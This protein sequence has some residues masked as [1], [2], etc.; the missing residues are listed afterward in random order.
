MMRQR[1][2]LGMWRTPQGRA[3]AERGLLYLCLALSCWLSSLNAQAQIVATKL[4]S[5][6]P[7]NG[8]PVTIDFRPQQALS[9]GTTYVWDLGRGGTVSGYYVTGVYPTAGT[10][11]VR[12]VVT[13][14]AGVSTTYDQTI[15]IFPPP[16][17][18]FTSNKTSGCFPLSVN[19]QDGTVP[20]TGST[21]VYR[22]WFFGDGNK[23]GIAN[24]ANTYKDIASAYNV[25]LRVVQDVCIGDTFQ[26]TRTSYI[27]VSEGVKPD[28]VMP[29]TT[30]CKVPATVTAQNRSTTGPG[31]TLS[32][33]W[34]VTGGTSSDNNAINF[35]A[36][37]ATAGNFTVKLVARSNGGC[38]DSIEKPISI[39][40][41]AVRSDF[42]IPSDTICQDIVVPFINNSS[43]FVSGSNIAPGKST[44]Y[45]GSDPAIEG[46]NQFKTFKATGNIQIKLVNEFGACKDSVTKLIH[47]I[48]SPDITV[49]GDRFSCKAPHLVNFSYTGAPA[50]SL[51]SIFWEFGNGLSFNGTGPS[52]ANA[53]SNYTTTGS[54]A[55]SLTVRNRFGCQ[56]RKIIDSFVV[57]APPSI[58]SSK[59]T[60]SGCVNF[61]FRPQVNIVAPDGVASYL[62]NFGDGTTQTNPNPTHTY[63]TA[64]TAPYPVSVTIV[65]NRGCTI[66][67]QG[68]VKIGVPPGTANFSATPRSLC[69]GQSVQFTDLSIPSPKGITGWYW[70]FGAGSARTQNPNYEYRDTGNFQVSLTV[71]NN[72]CPSPVKAISDYIRVGGAAAYFNDKNDCANRRQFQF[73]YST[74]IG[75][76]FEWDFGDGTTA[77]NPPDGF[78]HR[79]PADASYLVTVKASDGICSMSTSSRITVINET[80][81]YS[82]RSAFTTNTC[83]TGAI[84]FTA[85]G[86]IPANI[87]LYEWD[88]GNGVFVDG[89]SSTSH[90]YTI[91]GVYATRL[92]ITDKYRCTFTTAGPPLVIGSPKPSFQALRTQQCINLPVQF[93]DTSRTTAAILLASR[94][95]S[96]GDGTQITV[97]ASQ[98]T[99]QH[100]Y[101]SGG[102]Y[103]VK[104]ILKAIN[105]CEDSAMLNSYVTV[106][107]PIAAFNAPE[108]ES[109]SGSPVTF[110]NQSIL[111]GGS[112]TWDFG[113]GSSS[114]L[115]NPTHSYTSTGLYAVQLKVQDNLGCNSNIQKLDYIRVDVP[116]ASFNVSATFSSCPPFSPTFTFTGSYARS[117]SWDFGDGN[118]SNLATPSQIYLYPNTYSTRLTVTSPGGCTATSPPISIQVRGP[119]ATASMNNVVGCDSVR[120]QFSI[121]N[122]IDVTRV[123]WD[124][125]DGITSNQFVSSESHVYR[126]PG[127]YTPKII[128][129][130]TLG[131]KI[132][133]LF[134]LKVRNYGVIAGF[135]N[136]RTLFCDTGS[137]SLL[138]TSLI[139]GTLQSRSWNFGNGTNGTVANPTVKYNAPGRYD[140]TLMHTL[141]EG[142]GS[143]IVKPALVSVVQSPKPS[144]FTSSTLCPGQPILLRGVEVTVPRDTSLLQWSWDFGNG[145]RSTLQNPASQTYPTAGS[146][147]V[148]LQLKNSSGCIDSATQLL[149]IDTLPDI[150]VPSDTA[151]C[152]GKPASL[153]ASGASTYRWLPPNQGITCTTCPI[154]TVVPDSNR[155][156]LVEGTNS[157]GCV[158]YN[159]IRVEVIRPPKLTVTNLHNICIGGTARL[160]ASG[161]QFYAW[162]P[163][164]GL[165]DPTIANPIARPAATTL[166]VVTGEDRKRCFQTKDTARVE[167]YNFPSVFIGPTTTIRSGT[168]VQLKPVTSSDVNSYNWTPS[169]GLSCTNCRNPI[170]KPKE[171]IIYQL[172]ASNPGGCTSS[173]QVKVVVICDAENIYMPNTFS[174]NGDGMNEVF[175]GRGIG[176]KSIRGLRIFNRW[177][178]MVFQR[179]NVNIN[180]PSHGWDGRYKGKLLPPD[181]Y[182]YFIDVICDNFGLVTRKGDVA[183]I[184]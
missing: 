144:I 146:Y 145:L 116:I 54:F 140:I 71:F 1:H 132:P 184:R 69:A 17:I 81:A 42:T 38:V 180:D 57:I 49:T 21:I 37:F 34:S 148:K 41:L 109:C 177:G 183:L 70:Q 121:T 67:I 108:R 106:S 58:T 65:T 28:F 61:V 51:S 150:I 97:P 161:A 5:C 168:S 179:Q 171:T 156:Y 88:F 107:Q 92:R 163:T 182:V 176:V 77:L 125:D 162:S 63:T 53:S 31:Q 94:T 124:F 66:Q 153:Q 103:N 99:T 87:K 138:D 13:T 115:A 78:T 123:I 79:F 3:F 74:K 134:P 16:A 22:D 152:L 130:N 19:F 149:R 96:F 137:V 178:E 46:L 114:N 143:K 35:T 52:A 158:G 151:L 11:T 166:Y 4:A 175:Y 147:L 102:S 133:Y 72:G 64:Q 126:K 98:L 139:V 95:W 129:E 76:R 84:N 164:T 120:T 7:L 20:T 30:V 122:L 82:A 10:Y 68:A 104:L 60:D 59:L 159:S 50:S 8:A 113:D 27:Q 135:E 29:A 141:A 2:T 45:F 86:S 40:N 181:V 43:S 56:N 80:A 85:T 24:P 9:T 157:S 131:C 112:F 111:Q 93:E 110:I 47:V 136:S 173:G 48:A 6:I 26:I 44:W 23:S 105:G 170:A 174:P 55:I 160:S 154:T 169:T 36:Q 18:N 75:T 128:L 62:W 90:L 100:T 32:Y 172:T 89:P 101:T 73:N 83:K 119:S 167:V 15:Q 118:R 14:S 39:S 127:I 12:L 155:T 25:T 142:C 117:Y 165:S 33:L 91:E